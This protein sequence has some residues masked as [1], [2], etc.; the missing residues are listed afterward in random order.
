MAEIMP[1][2]IMEKGTEEPKELEAVIRA[3]IIWDWSVAIGV[4]LYNE[5]KPETA[6]GKVKYSL[7]SH[8]RP[9]LSLSGP[10][11]SGAPSLDAAATL[12]LRHWN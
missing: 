10:P 5:G 7:V 4:G 9:F 8:F 3:A 1:V 12:S 6:S 11:T 2:K